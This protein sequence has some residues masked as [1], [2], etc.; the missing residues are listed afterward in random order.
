M[1]KRQGGGGGI[2][3]PWII[4]NRANP[5]SCAPS[6][7]IFTQIAGF[8]FCSTVVAPH[9]FIFGTLT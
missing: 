2:C 7:L 6:L 5:A 3:F 4:E 1:G 8:H 9:V